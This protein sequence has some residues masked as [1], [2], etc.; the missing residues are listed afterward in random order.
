MSATTS[1]GLDTV[2]R[3]YEL[4]AAGRIDEVRLL[5]HEDLVIREPRDLPYGGDYHGRAGYD[6]IMGQIVSLAEIAVAESDPVQFLD[7][8]NPVVVH[9]TGRFTSRAT[10][11]V[12]ETRI[13][14][15]FTVRD[16]QIVELDVFYKEP[17][18]VTDALA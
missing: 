16:G 9:F 12:A 2:R 4:V 15:L 11:K 5:L 6:D 7:S 18:R 1:A 8:G 10:G 14:E 17:S 13:V 3:F